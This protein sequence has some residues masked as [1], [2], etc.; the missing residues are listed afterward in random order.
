MRREDLQHGSPRRGDHAEERHGEEHPEDAGDFAP[1]GDRHQHDRRVQVD[2][3]AVDDRGDEVAL[4]DVHHDRV[5]RHD[6]DVLRGPDGDRHEERQ[7]RRDEAA[8]VRDEP[9]D[10]GEDR[11]WQGKGQAQQDHDQVLRD[12][13]EQRH[14]AGADHVPA[15]HV[16]RA[17][18]RCVDLF[19]AIAVEPLAD[20]SPEALPVEQEVEAQQP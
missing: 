19:Q 18:G 3:A 8:D 4:H 11:Q 5:D 20:V 10:E 17:A 9:Q 2:R 13:P 12:G 15:E 7:A 16:D 6:R 1:G 14:A